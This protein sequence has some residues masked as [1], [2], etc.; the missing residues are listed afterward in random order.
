[1]PFK[2]PA[3]FLL[4]R[5][6]AFF[7]VGAFLRTDVLLAAARLVGA[8]FL[9]VRDADVFGTAVRVPFLTDW[10]RDVVFFLAMALGS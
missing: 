5:D 1:M 4:V 9:L 10:R 7:A 8:A 3:G 6:D 2:R